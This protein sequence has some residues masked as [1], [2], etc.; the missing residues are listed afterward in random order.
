MR[1]INPATNSAKK[2]GGSKIEIEKSVLPKTDPHIFLDC[3]YE[4][5]HEYTNNS[6]TILLC[7]RCACNRKMNSH[8]ILVCT[9]RADRKYLIEGAQLHKRIPARKPCVTDVLCKWDSPESNSRIGKCVCVNMLGPMAFQPLCHNSLV[10]SPDVHT[11]HASA[12]FGCAV[13]VL[14]LETYRTTGIHTF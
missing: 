10:C 12:Y 7:N 6:E 13:V 5:R 4:A 2:S 3:Y 8:R 11:Q 14:N 9:W 1:R